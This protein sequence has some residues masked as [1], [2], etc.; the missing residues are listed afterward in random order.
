MGEKARKWIKDESVKVHGSG[1]YKEEAMS[2]Y[3][4]FVLLFSNE[5]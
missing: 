2:V 4:D 1:V 5:V 3:K